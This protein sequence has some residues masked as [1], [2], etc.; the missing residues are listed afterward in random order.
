MYSRARHTAVGKILSALN[1]EFLGRSKCFFGGGTRVVLELKEYRES[2]DIDFLC[3]DRDGYRALRSTITN[4]SLGKM[5]ARPIP[6]AREV[7]AD[8]YGIRTIVSV[9]EELVK[10][11][12]VR[13][14]RIDL[15]GMSVRGI[16]APCLDRQCCFAEKILANDD[17]WIDESVLNRDVIDLAYMIEAWDLDLFLEGMR[18]AH[19]AY[20]DTVLKS[21]RSA[22]KKLIDEKT[23]LK[24]CVEGLRVT[25]TSTLLSG[26]RRIISSDWS[27]QMR[28]TPTR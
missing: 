8:Q 13:E 19:Q 7:K 25:K 15:G 4:I 21:V 3:S 2:A 12:I 22:A 16:H 1:S 10:F 24:K 20:G 5:A 18:L 11:E 23:Y 9:G 14:A 6:L 26:L 27:R 17:R 28:L